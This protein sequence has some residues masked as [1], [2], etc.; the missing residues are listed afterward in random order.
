MKLNLKMWSDMKNKEEFQN[1]TEE[2]L[3]KLDNDRKE[4]KE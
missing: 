1:A 4:L 2:V 3:W